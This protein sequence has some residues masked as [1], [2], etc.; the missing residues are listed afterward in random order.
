MTMRECRTCGEAIKTVAKKCP[1]CHAWQVKWGFDLQ[2]PLG[3]L[4]W[5]VLIVGLLIY[6]NMGVL[7]GKADFREYK[8]QIIIEKSELSYNIDGGKSYV[9]VIGTVRNESDKTWEDLHFEVRYFNVNDHLVDTNS[10]NVYDIVVPAHGKSA[11]RVRDRA[12]QSQ[13]SYDHYEIFIKKAREFDER[14]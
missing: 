2:S 9:G 12:A 6:L 7:G 11:F 5:F 14:F 13:S 3:G 4:I 1:H 8:N 10:E